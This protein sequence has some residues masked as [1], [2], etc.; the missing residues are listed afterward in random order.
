MRA[1]SKS[2]AF[3]RCKHMNFWHQRDVP[4]QNEG[5]F[6]KDV[7]KGDEQKKIR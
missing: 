2:N 1:F 6:G 5:T 4:V 7:V 3:Q